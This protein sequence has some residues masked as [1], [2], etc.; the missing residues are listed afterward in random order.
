MNIRVL[1]FVL[2]VD[3]GLQIVHSVYYDP[4]RRSLSNKEWP[5]GS[6]STEARGK[7]V[8]CHLLH[9]KVILRDPE[10]RPEG[11]VIQGVKINNLCYADD[12]DLMAKSE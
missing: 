6:P 1:A 12:A 4:T 3:K 5:S 10:D 9:P 2:T 7:D 11:V 8:S